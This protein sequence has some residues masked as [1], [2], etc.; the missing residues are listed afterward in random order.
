[1]K[2]Y[3]HNFFYP[4]SN[5]GL[6]YKLEHLVI[7]FDTTRYG[8]FLNISKY[9]MRDKSYFVRTIFEFKKYMRTSLLDSVSIDNYI[10]YNIFESLLSKPN[11]F[12]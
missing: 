7:E 3:Q 12:P 5:N 11:S 4:F 8:E 10:N 6:Q 2:K 9:F 1:M